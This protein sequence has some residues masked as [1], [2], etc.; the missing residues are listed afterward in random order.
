MQKK[1]IVGIEGILQP[2][3]AR[4]ALMAMREL[5]GWQGRLIE[6]ALRA[7]DVP[8]PAGAASQKQGKRSR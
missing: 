6:E 7:L 2:K 5:L 1:G 3:G 4:Q 8:A